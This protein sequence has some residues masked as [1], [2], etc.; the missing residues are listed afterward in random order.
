MKK[1]KFYIPNSVRVTAKRVKLQS[2]FSW[3]KALRP[4]NI[5]KPQKFQKRLRTNPTLALT[6]KALPYLIRQINP[7]PMNL[8][9][10]K[11]DL[12]VDI[13]FKFLAIAVQVCMLTI[14]LIS[15]ASLKTNRLVLYMKRENKELFTILKLELMKTSQLIL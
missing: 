6:A 14:Y 1:K 9:Q 10:L 13:E 11:K 15:L 2:H 3:I 8:K 5:R 12:R 4:N 7:S